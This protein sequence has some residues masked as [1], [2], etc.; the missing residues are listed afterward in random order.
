MGAARSGKARVLPSSSTRVSASLA[1]WMVRMLNFSSARAATLSAKA[2]PLPRP[3]MPGTSP[4]Q[5]RPLHTGQTRQKP[6][7]SLA[8]LLRIS[9]MLVLLFAGVVVCGPEGCRVRLYLVP[10]S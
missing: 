3:P 2:A 5:A 4:T 8:A 10:Y 6:L 7:I 1:S 9:F